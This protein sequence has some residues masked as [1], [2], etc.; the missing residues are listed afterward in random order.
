MIIRESERKRK[1]KWYD[2]ERKSPLITEYNTLSV[3]SF[4]PFRIDLFVFSQSRSKANESKSKWL[5]FLIRC[6]LLS[7]NMDQTLFLKA[8][9][10]QIYK[11]ILITNE[12][13]LDYKAFNLFSSFYF[14]ITNFKL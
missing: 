8:H 2:W 4:A 11:P 7:W 14:V 9:K 6:S 1:K 3:S 13:K 10:Y 12:I 5:V